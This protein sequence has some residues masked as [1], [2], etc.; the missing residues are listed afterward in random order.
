MRDVGGAAEPELFVF[1]PH[2]RNRR[3]RRDAIDL[4]DHEVVQHHVADDEDGAAG[5]P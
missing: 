2:D 4:A 1:E 3:F 5:E